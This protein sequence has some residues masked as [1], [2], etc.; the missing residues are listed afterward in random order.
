MARIIRV[1]ASEAAAKALISVGDKVPYAKTVSRRFICRKCH[2]WCL[3]YIPVFPPGGP[4]KYYEKYKK[5]PEVKVKCPNCV[6][7]DSF[8]DIL[9]D[10]V[11]AK[12]PR[13][14]IRSK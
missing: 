13:I 7:F 2:S 14:E 10:N 8:H 4:R 3:E 12:R 5:L 11:K 9:T 1:N 6:Q